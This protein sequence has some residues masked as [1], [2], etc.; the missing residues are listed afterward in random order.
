MLV[1]IALLDHLN[2][3]YFSANYNYFL[4]GTRGNACCPNHWHN[5]AHF[6]RTD[7]LTD[8]EAA[9]PPGAAGASLA[10]TESSSGLISQ[11]SGRQLADVKDETSTTDAEVS[12][13]D[14]LHDVTFRKKRARPPVCTSPQAVWSPDAVASTSAAAS[15]AG[16]TS[17][18]AVA[19]VGRAARALSDPGCVCGTKEKPADHRSSGY[20]LGCR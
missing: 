2:R 20:C 17:S 7:R 9:P 15:L 8:E 19:V 5:R 6:F 13:R 4:S 3:I 14:G 16:T 10:A 18:T 11:P 12:C 1:V